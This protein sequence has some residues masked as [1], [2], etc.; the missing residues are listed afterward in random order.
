MRTRPSQLL[1]I[2]P[3][4]PRR[5]GFERIIAWTT[6]IRESYPAG[7][8]VTN[9]GKGVCKQWGEALIEQSRLTHWKVP[10]DVLSKALCKIP[11]NHINALAIVSYEVCPR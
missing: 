10:W 8:H 4:F 3:Q 6:G 7:C 9:R 5:S 11:N 2:T 1:A